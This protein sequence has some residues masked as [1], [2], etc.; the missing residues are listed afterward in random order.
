[1]TDDVRHPFFSQTPPSV[2]SLRSIP[3]FTS[4]LSRR[5]LWDSSTPSLPPDSPAIWS[6]ASTAPSS[7]RL[8]PQRLDMSA[9]HISVAFLPEEALPGRTTATCRSSVSPDQCI[10]AAETINVTID[11]RITEDDG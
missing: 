4:S 3:C 5:K 11:R 8:E 10:T 7:R 2:V 1:M 9:D 6:P